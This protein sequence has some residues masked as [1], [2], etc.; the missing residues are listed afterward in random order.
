MAW[1][2]S[3]PYTKSFGDVALGDNMLFVN[4]SGNLS[5]AINQGNFANTYNIESGTDWTIEIEKQ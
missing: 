4:S 3:V 1:Q 5:I 2:G